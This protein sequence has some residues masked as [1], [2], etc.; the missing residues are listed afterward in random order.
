MQAGG[1]GGIGGEGEAPCGALGAEDQKTK[2][3][4]TRN[5]NNP[6][7]QLNGSKQCKFHA[8]RMKSTLCQFP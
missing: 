7:L 3:I 1:G 8:R 4:Q 2:T 6:L 5:I